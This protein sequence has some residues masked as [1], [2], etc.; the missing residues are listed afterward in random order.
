[1]QRSITTP[2]VERMGVFLRMQYFD[3]LLAALFVTAD[4]G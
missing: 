1:M 3:M 4:V 2:A